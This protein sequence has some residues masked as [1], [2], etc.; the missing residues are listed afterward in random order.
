MSAT[1]KD[2]YLPE[3]LWMI[4]KR[5]EKCGNLKD[6]DYSSEVENMSS[7]LKCLREKLREFKPNLHKRMINV[8]ELKLRI[9][10]YWQNIDSKKGISEGGLKEWI[11]DLKIK[12]GNKKWMNEKELRVESLVNQK[13][14]GKDE[15]KKWI[16][17]IVPQPVDFTNSAELEI[18]IE[19]LRQKLEDKKK[20]EL[21][22][23]AEVISQGNAKIEIRHL[24]IK[25]HQ[26]FVAAN[27]ETRLVCQII[28]LELRRSY[29]LSPTDMNTVIEGLKGLLDNPMSKIIIRADITSFFE[30]IPQ[31]ELID[32][33]RDDGFIARRSL[34]Y[35]RKM[36]YEYNR[37][38]GNHNHIGVPRGLAFSSY[39]SELY[40]RPIDKKIKRMNGVYYYKRYVDD[41]VLV[42]DPTVMKPEEYWKELS[43]I[44]QDYKLSLHEDSQKKFI[45][46]LNKSTKCAHFEYLGYKFIFSKEKLEVQLSDKRFKKYHLLIDAIFE[47]YAKCANHHTVGKD[48]LK[49]LF[50]RLKML[51]S[52]GVLSGRKNYVATG[53]FY[54]NKHLTDDCQL[55]QLDDYLSSV[56]GNVEKFNPPKTLFNYKEEGNDYQKNLDRI[57][58]KLHGYSFREGF[59]NRKIYKSTRDSRTLLGLQRIYHKKYEQVSAD[60]QI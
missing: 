5:E 45:C 17:K 42:L 37:I 59:R 40:M 23:K 10:K 3:F 54:S 6:K 36:M 58:K 27:I 41:I 14:I 2:F 4:M 31:Q 33:L 21:T 55:R 48:A 53:I 11:D 32:K 57:K 51:T 8:A 12:L 43:A 18:E 1:Q 26:T 7:M 34:K 52:N 44:F 16:E 60:F 39:L 30:S 15:L 9:E 24:E 25:S 35:L 50:D 49:E 28:K 46:L 22:Q 19:E 56:I 38:S 29:K 13:W 47:I 20:E